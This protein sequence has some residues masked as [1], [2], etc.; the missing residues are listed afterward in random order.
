MFGGGS[1]Q[2]VHPCSGADALP[3]VAAQRKTE[4]GPTAARSKAFE[5]AEQAGTEPRQA[6]SKE[7]TLHP[8]SSR[9]ELLA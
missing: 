7:T 4:R 2:N 6:E 9:W 1:E 3:P 5:I 8:Q